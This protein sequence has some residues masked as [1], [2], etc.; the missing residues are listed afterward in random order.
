MLISQ[1]SCII[2][3]CLYLSL[4]RQNHR[5]ADDLIHSKMAEVAELVKEV[6][7]K[8]EE[9]LREAT[10]NL[11]DKIGAIQKAL[12]ACL[13]RR[14]VKAILWDFSDLTNHLARLIIL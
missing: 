13:D 7:R 4:P 10:R 2:N 1:L 12:D 11:E 5:A 8:G 14:Q 3:L 6:G 9:Q